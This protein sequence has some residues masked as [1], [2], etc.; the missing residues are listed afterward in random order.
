MINTQERKNSDETWIK[1][2]FF[3]SERCKLTDLTNFFLDTKTPNLEQFDFKFFE[4]LGFLP[5][6]TLSLESS[7]EMISLT[8]LSLKI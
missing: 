1:N 6:F 8:I 5:S 2:I 7:Y 3:I 4:K